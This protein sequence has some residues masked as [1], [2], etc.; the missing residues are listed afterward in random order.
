MADSHNGPR[1]PTEPK[2][3]PS[4]PPTTPESVATSIFWPEHPVS[5]DAPT[6]ISRTKPR[7]VHAEDLLHSD[8]RGRRLAHFELLEPIGAGGMAAVLRARDTQ[9]D[10]IVALKILPPEVASNPESILRFQHE[11]RA[12]AKLDHENIARVFFCGEDQ[13]LHFISFEFVDGE[14]LRAHIQNHGRLSAP[15]AVNY[16]VQIA[17]GLAHAAERGVVH[18][19]I[20]PSNI[21]ITPD[22]RAKLV[23]MGLAR[24]V[25]PNADIALTQSGVTLGSF[26]YIS[27]EQAMEPREADT[28]SDIYSLGCT[29]YHAL[30][31]QTPVPDGTAA[32]KLHHH[33][34][35]EP[36]DPRQ[37]N[38]DIPEELAGILARMM[39]KDPKDRYQRPEDLVHDLLHQ[40]DK[41]GAA[42]SDSSVTARRMPR[43]LSD[44]ST[45]SPKPERRRNR[46]AWTVGAA[47]AILLT[48]FFVYGILSRFHW[49]FQLAA[50]NGSHR[51]GTGEPRDPN[52]P[53]IPGNPERENKTSPKIVPQ[54]VHNLGELA[55]ALGSR[56]PQIDVRLAT[57]LIDL[58]R[59][60][61]RTPGLV[62]A[63]D[64]GQLTIE[65]A[66]NLPHR[67]VIKLTYNAAFPQSVWSALTVQKGRVTLRH[68]RFE[69]DATEAPDIQM[70]AVRLQETGELRI[71]DCE[72]VQVGPSPKSWVSSILVEG[73]GGDA[74]TSR[75]VMER[76]YFVGQA[77][78]DP[79]APL[80]GQ[81]AITLEG[82]AWVRIFN[83]AFGPH[84][85]LIHFLKGKSPPIEIRNV[86]ALMTDGA[87][88]S[89][90]QSA[91]VEIHM[92]QSLISCP[93]NRLTHRGAALI[94]QKGGL[95]EDVDF[96]G[97][98]NCY[99]D[100]D[101]FWTINGQ[102]QVAKNWPREDQ[103]LTMSPWSDNEP[104]AR[105]RESKPKQ[106][107][108]V[109]LPELRFSDRS[110]GVY[111]CTW[112]L[113]NDPAAPNLEEKK[114]ELAG[115]LIVDPSVTMA[116][117]R[118]YPRLN[119][120][121]D[122]ARPGDTILLK[123][124]RDRLIKIDMIRL[125]KPDIN[126]TIKPY[127]GF[128]PILTLGGS[129]EQEASMFRL[130]DGKLILKDLEF[131]LKSDPVDFQS[132]AVVSVVGDGEC[133][134]TN[135]VV[136][137][138]KGDSNPD[139][140]FAF[141]TLLDTA[142]V[143][144]MEPQ[145]PPR[146]PDIRLESCFI[147]GKGEMLAVRSSRPFRLQADKSL[148]V[149]DGNFLTVKGSSRDVPVQSP[150][151]IN[152]NRVTTYL[153][154][155]LVL[156]RATEQLAKNNKG[157]VP[158]QVASAT[159]CLF[160]A[161]ADKSL[162]HL[163]GVDNPEDMTKYFSW[164][165]D[166]NNNF[167]KFDRLL[168]QQSPG[169]TT[170]PMPYDRAKWD[171]FTNNNGSRYETVKF[172]A[173]PPPDLTH[174][175]ASTFKVAQSANTGTPDCGA[176]VDD[177]PV[178][179]NNGGNTDR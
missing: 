24:S 41:F 33:Q 94:S 156:L 175:P 134:I 115:P 21:I 176:A 147:R 141:V 2:E 155:H 96:V 165:G 144:K 58:T 77:P 132:R 162:I 80:D 4:P 124:G 127:E 25:E 40:G 66:E 51:N 104:L 72:F 82:A 111:R 177:L 75:L 97:G 140:D 167:S 142:N 119:T 86:S 85:A 138:D 12:A 126:L 71:E 28:R 121:I 78:N 113:V 15:E 30:T 60:H 19:D 84:S 44:K 158:T 173:A 178:P 69:V 55:T 139:R 137:L 153:T 1:G 39:A 125:E 7:A 3:G 103:L 52:S 18:R 46:L 34:S 9:L 63:S 42:S 14:T 100:L 149:L 136:T 20:K 101:D 6:I 129:T 68:L 123:C 8:L 145:A 161:A 170:A 73:P 88:F 35:V 54:V 106:A 50:N 163:D 110:L 76:C 128:H 57:D 133:T 166:R 53:D 70:A 146:S 31:G 102:S 37:L 87:V 114:T 61:D 116:S 154:H 49:P 79:F 107:F 45:R 118:I 108:R 32:K 93:N 157:L 22:G 17:G 152:L 27:P 172:T 169:Q 23:D 109:N 131:L 98:G 150:S 135:C 179:F 64:G 112:G 38:P 26:D 67:P 120:A 168:D 43:A 47:A 16:L 56:Q 105:L 148:V 143:M 48:G 83:C 36:I 92:E 74:S 171:S 90:E 59:D 65:P 99:H 5:D 159:E 11:A 164:A 160:A 13:G 130:H 117:G 62:F 95:A 29:F 122:D 174:V 151:T 89:V 81:N 10:R 91:Q